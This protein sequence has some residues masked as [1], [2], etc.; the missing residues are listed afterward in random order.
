MTPASSSVGADP[1]THAEDQSWQ[2]GALVKIVLNNSYFLR[3]YFHV[4]STQLVRNKEQKKP[5]KPYD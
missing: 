5:K 2:N 1:E 3:I 4:I